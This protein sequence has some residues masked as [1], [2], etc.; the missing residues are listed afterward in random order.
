MTLRERWRA[1]PGDLRFGYAAVFI[2]GAW[3][4][5]SVLVGFH[6][7]LLASSCLLYPLLATAAIVLTFQFC[8]QPSRWSRAL[9]MG[10]VSGCLA[11]PFVA[12]HATIDLHL[13]LS[14]YAAG[15]PNTIN[16]WGQELIREQQGKPDSRVVEPNR[17]PSGVHMF[18]PGFVTV[19]GALRIERGGGFYH[20]GVMIY[21]KGSV[22]AADWQRLLGWPPEVVVYHEE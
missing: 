6:L 2:F 18:L 5:L 9:P 12:P 17:I 11:L 14:I 4:S 19:D 21:P 7:L 8:V 3:F 1:V 15:G 10:L 13:I 22:P 20:Y 16:D